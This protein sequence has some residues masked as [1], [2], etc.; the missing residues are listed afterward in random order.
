MQEVKPFV[1]ASFRLGK[2]V[3]TLLKDDVRSTGP[4]TVKASCCGVEIPVKIT[5]S[6]FSGRK[7]LDK[8]G[9]E[10]PP[11]PNNPGRLMMQI[12]DSTWKL[13][14]PECPFRDVY[15]CTQC[16]VECF[17]KRQFK[18]HM[19]DNE[20]EHLKREVKQLKRRMERKTEPR[21]I[22]TWHLDGHE[23]L[24]EAP[25]YAI[26]KY[27][28]PASCCGAQIPMEVTYSPF[29]KPSEYGKVYERLPCNPLGLFPRVDDSTW[30][31]HADGCPFQKSH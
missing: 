27:M 14:V 28:V 31:M 9:V 6:I 13:H 5:M 3:C 1:K 30:A 15:K 2:Q 11:H 17:T 23:C 4:C 16:G 22:S 21:V 12:D 29:S 20:V 26:G 7:V 18:K 19:K 8:H 10:I 25:V 24:L